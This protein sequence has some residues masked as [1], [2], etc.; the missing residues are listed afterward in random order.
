MKIQILKEM[1]D[2]N[3]V[4]E[5]SD[6]SYV[7]SNYFVSVDDDS[8]ELKPKSY[9]TPLPEID[10]EQ[11]YNGWELSIDLDRFGVEVDNIQIN[12]PV[13]FINKWVSEFPKLDADS[14]SFTDNFRSLAVSIAQKS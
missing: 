14:S 13:A 2:N 4:S 9:D 5:I 8:I 10:F 3:T 1:V 7:K 11:E 6:N 12:S